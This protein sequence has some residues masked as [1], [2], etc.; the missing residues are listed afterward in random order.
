MEGDPT[1]FEKAMRSVYSSKWQEGM[2]VK[3]NSMNTNVVWD[4]E[5]I[6]NRVKTV[7]CKWV[8]KTKCDSKGYVERYKA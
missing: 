2:E 3:M 8:C 4:L 7:G 5:E 6:P 1:S